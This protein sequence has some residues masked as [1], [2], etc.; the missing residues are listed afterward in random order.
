M[1]R[2]S[3]RIDV[4]RTAGCASTRAACNL[5]EYSRIPRFNALHLL[6]FPQSS[7]HPLRRHTLCAGVLP[8]VDFRFGV[9]SV[10]RRPRPNFI[11][12]RRPHRNLGGHSP[13]M[14]GAVRAALMHDAVR[15]KLAQSR[16]G[17]S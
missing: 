12:P 10:Q 13:L 11:L 7:H 17:S 3:C 16:S 14:E 15:S 8:S 6:R 2:S 1:G 5:R 9:L 4:A